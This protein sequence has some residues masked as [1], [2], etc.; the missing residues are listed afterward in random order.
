MF[1]LGYDRD[2]QV[3][4]LSQ[5]VGSFSRTQIVIAVTLVWCVL[6]LP[7]ALVMLWRSRGPAL[8]PED[9]A[10]LDFCKRLER[11]G[12]VRN[13]S[14]AP[15]SFAER[16]CQ[17]FP[18]VANEVMAITRGYQRIAFEPG[19]ASDKLPE[20]RRRIRQFTPR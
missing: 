2:Y 4:L 9:R 14:E 5:F 12:L 17:A 19:D 16:A 7:V 20:L 10:Y 18:A 13:G 1:V 8:R 3:D 6:L 11:R 15:G